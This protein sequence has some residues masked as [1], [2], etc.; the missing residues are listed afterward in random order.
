MVTTAGNS[1]TE[2]LLENVNKKK[3]LRKLIDWLVFNTNFN[4]LSENAEQMVLN[5]KSDS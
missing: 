3:F 1:L 4:N 5:C 2:V